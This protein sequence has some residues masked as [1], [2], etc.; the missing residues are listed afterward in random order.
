M[1]YPNTSQ[2]RINCPA[3][4]HTNFANFTAFPKKQHTPESHFKRTKIVSS[5]EP[6]RYRI[7]ALWYTI[8]TLIHNSAQL[9]NF[10]TLFAVLL[11]RR[12]ACFN[13]HFSDKHPC[14]S[15]CRAAANNGVVYYLANFHPAS[16][17]IF[18]IFRHC[19]RHHQ[20][21]HN[22]SRLKCKRV[23]IKYWQ[24]QWENR[25]WQWRHRVG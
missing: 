15:S 6:P 22:V 13:F 8:V 23:L 17:F 7:H 16:N 25:N 12:A 14:G 1:N 9:R 5:L 11:I 18:F 19:D 24:A 4:A 21:R 3:A 2:F 10:S 20:Q